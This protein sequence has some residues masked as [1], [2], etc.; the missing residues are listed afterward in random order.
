M[1]KALNYI[2][3]MMKGEKLIVQLEEDDILVQANHWSTELIG[4]VLG[5]SLFFKTM[6]NY[7]AHVWNFVT[8]PKV[9][10]HGDGYYIFKFATVA[11]RD[12]VMPSGAYTYRNRPPILKDWTIDFE[13]NPECLNKNVSLNRNNQSPSPQ[14]II[15]PVR[16]LSRHASKSIWIP[17]ASG[18]KC[19]EDAMN[20]ELAALEENYA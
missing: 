11:D 15:D 18:Q 6:K 20:E 2:P 17:Q 7:I 3:P 10:Y 1:G 19:W 4:Y 14:N 13:F 9:L 8:K 16:R 5:D 12:L